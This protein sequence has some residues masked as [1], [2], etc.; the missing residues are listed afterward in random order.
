MPRALVLLTLVLAACGG[1]SEPPVV[2]VFAASSLADAF[3]EI[4]AAYEAGHPGVEVRLNLAGSSAL[5]EQ[6]LEGAPADVFAA[7]DESTMEALVDA[8]GV[9]GAPVV[10]AVNRLV[11][12]VPA[13][14][15]A[16]VS[17]L[18]D[19]AD[20]DLLVGLCSAGVPCGD[21]ARTVLAR[22]GVSASI[23]TDEP[24]VRA[25]AAKIADGELDAGLVYATDIPTGDLAALPIPEQVDATTN[26][27]IA[28]LAGAADDAAPFVDYV[29]SAEG[30]GILA[31]YGFG[32]P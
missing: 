3:T 14:N 24:N 12:A 22:A 25:L 15:P 19:F 8:G 9:A 28:A 27:T 30:R 18:A 29:R 11:I 5:R 20:P 4:A 31:R 10:F 32:L 7:A 2:N 16:A 1:R 17:G 13:G 26:Y 23:D 21:L 6:I